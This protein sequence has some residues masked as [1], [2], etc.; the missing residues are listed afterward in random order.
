MPRTGS[1]YDRHYQAARARLL[2]GNPRCHICGLPGADSADHVPALSEHRHDPRGCVCVLR[3]A[4]LRCNIRRGGWRAA[5]KVRQRNR[6]LGIKPK[7][8]R[9]R[10]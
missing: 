7:P 2:A 6:I 3:P 4:H 8:A 9:R 10:R 5:V 1:N